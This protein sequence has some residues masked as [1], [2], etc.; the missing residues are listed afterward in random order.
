M[1]T[2]WWATQTPPALSYPSLWDDIPAAD[3][4]GTWSLFEAGYKLLILWAVKLA[5]SKWLTAPISKIRIKHSGRSHENPK[6][7][8]F[9]TLFWQTETFTHTVLRRKQDFSKELQWLWKME[10]KPNKTHVIW[11][12]KFRKSILKKV[13]KIYHKIV[14]WR[15]YHQHI[16]HG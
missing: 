16:E 2:I 10:M 15:I 5:S 6:A 4:K 11:C 3:S 7:L 14:R 12:T 8:S 1:T 9:E 13:K